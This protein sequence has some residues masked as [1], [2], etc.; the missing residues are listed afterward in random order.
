MAGD[1]GP[2]AYCLYWITTRVTMG[3]TFRG[4]V[5]HRIACGYVHTVQTASFTARS[6]AAELVVG[7]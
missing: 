3:V 7:D 6:R 2:I 5:C 1:I 4:G